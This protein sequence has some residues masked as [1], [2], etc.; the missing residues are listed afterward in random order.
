[1]SESQH[2]K[3][4][5]DAL[6]LDLD[7]KNWDVVRPTSKCLHYKGT[8]LAPGGAPSEC[9]FCESDATFHLIPSLSYVIICS[10]DD[11]DGVGP[12]SKFDDAASYLHNVIE[13]GECNHEHVIHLVNL[14]S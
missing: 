3:N 13:S 2:M 9:G 12:F 11:T 4:K 10:A 14:P 7:L 5:I 1:M 8:G 6:K